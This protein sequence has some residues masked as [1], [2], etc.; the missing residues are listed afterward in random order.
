MKLASDILAEH[1]FFLLAAALAQFIARSR[2]RPTRSEKSI[3]SVI[4]G[5]IGPGRL[6]M[7]KR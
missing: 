5:M 4:A 2:A 6:F 7:M 1:L 3:R